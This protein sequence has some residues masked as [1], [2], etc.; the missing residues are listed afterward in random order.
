MALLKTLG[1]A[2]TL[3]VNGEAALAA[4]EHERFDIV[5]MDIQMPVIDG[6]KAL[7]LLREREAASG[8]HTPVIALT[9]FAL[10][11]DAERFLLDGFDG[12][13]SKPLLIQDLVATIRRTMSATRTTQTEKRK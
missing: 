1:Y 8:A 9:A 10:K 5:L 6:R 7:G 4:L 2:A 11:G 3:A 12:Y 13:L